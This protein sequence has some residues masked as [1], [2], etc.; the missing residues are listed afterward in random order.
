MDYFKEVRVGAVAAG[1]ALTKDEEQ[2]PA[3]RSGVLRFLKPSK[4]TSPL[5]RS[6]IVEGFLIRPACDVLEFPTEALYA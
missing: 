4:M 1:E 3:A 5:A 2:D 6:L